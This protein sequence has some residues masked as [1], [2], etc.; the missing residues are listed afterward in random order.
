MNL[1]I[2]LR[3]TRNSDN[4]LY[5]SASKQAYGRH[6]G[7]FVGSRGAASIKRHNTGHMSS[8]QGSIAFQSNRDSVWDASEQSSVM[9][10]ET[11]SVASKSHL[12]VTQ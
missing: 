4:A 11:F 3:D 1:D 2:P 9:V 8:D 10:R 6:T 7:S 5:L 12:S